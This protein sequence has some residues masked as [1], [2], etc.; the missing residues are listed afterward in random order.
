MLNK[1][2]QQSYSNTKMLAKIRSLVFDFGSTDLVNDFI[3]NNYNKSITYFDDDMEKT[4]LYLE[5]LS[6]GEVFT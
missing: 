4:A 6:I 2:Q 1:D 3:F 5:T